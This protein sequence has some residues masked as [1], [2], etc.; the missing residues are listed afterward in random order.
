MFFLVSCFVPCCGEEKTQAQK[1][2]PVFLSYIILMAILFK[3]FLEKAREVHGEKFDYSLVEYK[4]NSDKIKIICPIHGEFSQVLRD[5]LNKN[6][7]IKCKTKSL[8]DF[9]AESRKIH[10]ELYDYSLTEYKNSY[11]KVKIICKIHGEFF[12]APYAHRR[13]QGCA[14]CKFD[15]KRLG[16]ERF[17]E[18]CRETHGNFYNYDRLVY[19]KIKNKVEIGCPIHGY[20]LQIADDHQRGIGCSKCKASKGEIQIRKYLDTNCI[21]YEEQK[22]FDTCKYKRHLLFDFYI[23]ALNLLIEYQGEQHFPFSD[24]G[25]RMFGSKKAKELHDLIILRDQIK[26]EWAKQNGYRLLEISHK[27]FKQIEKILGEE[28]SLLP[29]KD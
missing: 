22:K 3:D 2:K 4:H 10:G 6:G 23:P 13:G 29:I 25:E 11:T 12:Q 27:D 14:G 18:I 5:H 17:L 9:I 19:T 15:Q 16:Q 7:C 24:K 8:D 28:L 26:Q 1:M 21:Y 20:F